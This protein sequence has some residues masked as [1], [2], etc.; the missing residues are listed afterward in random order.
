MKKYILILL[1]SFLLFSCCEEEEIKD[2]IKDSRGIAGVYSSVFQ[3]RYVKVSSSGTPETI[4]YENTKIRC[5]FQVRNDN[6]YYL[7]TT[8]TV[9]NLLVTSPISIVSVI[10]TNKII[11]DFYLCNNGAWTEGYVEGEVCEDSIY[12]IFTGYFSFKHPYYP[13]FYTSTIL[14]GHFKLNK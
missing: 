10:D 6:S 8:D 12:G 7:Y 9:N 11:G 14:D 5:V 13:T 1:G 2:E 4:I 3:G